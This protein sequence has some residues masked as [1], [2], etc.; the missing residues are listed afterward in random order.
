MLT[1]TEAI[2]QLTVNT[3]VCVGVE[4]LTVEKSLGRVIAN[5]V[6]ASINVPPANNSAM[7]GYAFCYRDA[8]EKK[9]TLPLSQS[10]VAGQAPKALAKYTTARIFTG[11]EIPA[12]ADT[13]ATQEHCYEQ[14]GLVALDKLVSMGE[15]V[16]PQGQD[17][18]YGKR[19]LSAGSLIRPQEMGLLSSLGIS[20]IN[21]YKVL[22]V[23]F[24]TTGDELKS[25]GIKLKAGQI[26]DSNC[27]LLTG[28]ISSLGMQPV[29][30][31]TVGDNLE[32]IKKL[33]QS[34]A[35][36]VDIILTSGG[37]S[38][39]DQ[40]YLKQAVS[41]LGK[42]NFWKVAIKP[43]KPI[44]YGKVLD[45]AYLGLPG[46]P[47]SVF[48]AFSI[49]ARP[50]LLKSQGHSNQKPLLQKAKALFNRVA[51]RR[52]VYLRGRLIEDC[53]EIQDNQSSGML[54]TACWANT[55]VIQPANTKIKRGDKVDLLPFSSLGTT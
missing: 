27:N 35:Q 38:V 32:D 25:P 7:D 53:V 4:E 40:D 54:S 14:S 39:G 52:E 6:I 55:F 21:V 36:Q 3:T 29:N 30:L 31:G 15:N 11:S 17:V 20:K 13:V 18:T 49:L 42:I 48:V 1:V 24:F 44:V 33:L 12:G 37:V 45:T 51:E 43:G 16:R 19:I 10:I 47:S 9:F 26:Y 46:N 8:V 34:A 2:Q 5:D 22:K 41:E 50:L 28:L 23:G